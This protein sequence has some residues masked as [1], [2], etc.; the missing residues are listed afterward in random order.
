MV[1]VSSIPG[2]FSPNGGPLPISAIKQ[3]A[4]STSAR[5]QGATAIGLISSGRKTAD[6]GIMKEDEGDLQEALLKYYTVAKCVVLPH[7]SGVTGTEWDR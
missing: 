2:T 5:L 3:Q 7:R 4:Q 1:L 6:A